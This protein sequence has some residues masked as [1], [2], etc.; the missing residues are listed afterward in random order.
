[1]HANNSLVCSPRPSIW[2]WRRLHFMEE[3]AVRQRD[4]P[5]NRR[6]G[7]P[8]TYFKMGLPISGKA[9]RVEFFFLSP[10][11]T[12]DP[13]FI[14]MLGYLQWQTLYL[15]YHLR[16]W[17]NFLFYNGSVFRLVHS[18]DQFSGGG[19][20]HKFFISSPSY[21]TRVSWR[22]ECACALTYLTVR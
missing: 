8:I 15:C 3:T 10:W 1:M 9:L 14:N 7:K 11:P 4:A 20:R 6:P 5:I 17:T 13:T 16:Q 18:V 19:S 12:Q 21:E 22:G 2:P